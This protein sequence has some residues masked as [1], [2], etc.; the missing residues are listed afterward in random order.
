MQSRDIP[1]QELLEELAI[2]RQRVAHLEQLV[3]CQASLGSEKTPNHSVSNG[4]LAK[5]VES[6]IKKLLETNSAASP[7]LSAIVQRLHQEILQRDALLEQMKMERSVPESHFETIL[8]QMP[9]GVLIVDAQSGQPILI[10][11]QIKQLLGCSDAIA[12]NIE[13]FFPYTNPTYLAMQT[14]TT[15]ETLNEQEVNFVCG[16]GSH[17]VAQISSTLV[18]TND[19]MTAA[20]VVF[21]DIT[22]R[23]RTEQEL[24]RYQVLSEH[25][26]DI[27]L[28][29]SV[30]GRILEANQAAVKAYGYNREQLLSLS[31]TDL[32]A[33][34]THPLIPRQLEQARQQGILFETLHRRQDGSLFPVEVSAQ[35]TL[36]NGETVILSIIREITERQHAQQEREQLLAREQSAR[37][38]AETAER[39]AQFLVEA[40]HLLS[41]SLDYEYTLKS[42]A[43]SIVPTLADWCA[44]DI[45]VSDGSLQRL[46][47]TH[48][49]PAKVEWALEIYRRYPPDLN[50]PRGIAHVLRT[51]QP[52]YYPE[53]TDEQIVAVARDPEHL[54][55]LRGVGFSSA[56]IVPLIA[57]GK[58]L[59]TISLIAAESGHSYSKD[60]LILAEE[61]ARRAAIA[62]DNARLYQEA[63][64]ARQAAERAADRTARL[65][66]VTA[67]LAEFL[68]PLQV[69]EVIVEQSMT[70]L[71]ADG[72]VMALLVDESELEIVKIEGYDYEKSAWQ[73]FSID[74]PVPLAEAVRTKQP[75][76]PEAP[77]DRFTRYPHLKEIYKRLNFEAWISLPLV[78]EGKSVGGLSLSFRKFKQIS[79]DDRDFMLALTSQCA[80]AIARSRLYEAERK[81]RADAEQA[82]RIKDEFLAVLSHE[83]RSPLNPILGWTKLLRTRQLD[84]EKSDRA[85]ETI[86]RNAKLQAQLVEDLLDVSRIL[87]G[88]MV[89]NVGS[90]NLATTIEA[91]LETVRLSA[92]AKAIQIQTV[93]D[94]Q[95]GQVRGD[96]NRLQQVV[97]NLLSNAVKFTPVGGRV[98]IRL[99]QVGM[100]AQ[101]QVSDTGKGIRPNFL[102]Y[103]FDYFR[104]EDGSTT[105]HFGGLGLGL[106]IVRQVVE[107]HGGTVHAES[108]GE[109]L[110]ATFAIRLPSQ[111]AL[112]RSRESFALTEALLPAIEGIRVLVVDDE[113]DARE[114]IAFLLEQAGAIVTAVSSAHDA[115]ESLK[116]S[117]P[118]ILISDIGMSG[119][120]GYRLIRQVRTLTPEEGGQI[121]A[122]ALTAYA[123]ELNQ[124]QALAAGFQQHITKPLDLAEL[125]QVIATLAEKCDRAS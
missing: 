71:E 98:E 28:Y 47:T 65:Q 59:G 26:R 42:V 105:R 60:D 113:A 10:N 94:P 43:Q 103:V 35:S 92:E 7:D 24:Q 12:K 63:Q 49:D 66:A 32:R 74:A 37:A 96:A 20:V 117:K 44:V 14:L 109:G 95:V 57:R 17:R 99:E 79:Q 107:L 87:R 54:K 114:L 69:A 83:L 23:K 78:V 90:V 101:I 70:V 8:H 50:A 2:L 21:Q 100:D 16:D 18:Q 118:D 119:M 30:D 51:G 1:Y 93:F 121:L 72:A 15:G 53:V 115:L 52:E 67:A 81:A 123:G 62:L 34:N 97:W 75:V 124:Q 38:V 68:T 86:E 102:P 80:Q 22:E 122:I 58:S 31:I 40:S 110:G 36:I 91:A 5:P 108:Q 25:S 104:Q 45:L 3:A 64:Q 46:A 120:D 125:I 56:M 33:S 6:D 116:Q 4:K 9:T 39:R 111:Q 82:N 27:V 89:L 106:A 13:H 84:R 85:L 29:L 19:E 48:I 77:D 61:L 55:M 11:Q 73:R 88:K 76:W 41:S 112:E